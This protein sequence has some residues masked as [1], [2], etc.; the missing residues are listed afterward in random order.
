MILPQSTGLKYSLAFIASLLLFGFPLHAFADKVVTEEWQISADKITRYDNPQSIIAEGNIVL[1]KR[2]KLPPKPVK[3]DLNVTDWSVLLEEKPQVEQI[4]PKDLETK[5]KARYVTKVTIKADWMA[6]DVTLGTI[7]ARGHVD[8]LSGDERLFAEQGVVNLTRDTGTFTNA[9]IIRKKNELHLEGKTI[10]KTGVHTYRILDGWA[11]TCKVDKGE[12]SPWSFSSKDTKITQGGYAVMKNAK[13]NI[14]GVPVFY[15]PFMV[16]PIKNTRETGFLFPEISTSSNNGYGFNLPFFY[17]I[18]DSADMT[19]YSEYYSKRG[20]M[21]GAEF[22][23]VLEPDDKGTFA[24][25]YLKDQ[26]SDP[27]ETQYYRDTGF[28]HT[29]DQR[30][31]V[32]GKIDKTFGDGWITRVDLDIVSDRDYLTE[33]NSSNYTGFRQSNQQFLDAFGRGFQDKTADQRQ[34]AVSVLKS[35]KGMSLVTDLLAINDVRTNKTSPTPLWKLPEIDFTGATPINNSNF[36]FNWDANYVDYWRKDGVGANRID[37]SP[38][39]SSPIPLGPYLESRAEVGLRETVYQ[40]QAYGDGSWDQGNNPTRTLYN[41]HTE[42]GTTLAR[43]FDIGLDNFKGINH[44]V[45]PF[46][47]YDYIPD[48]NQNDLPSFDGIDRINPANTITYGVD[49]FFTL[50]KDAKNLD[51]DSTKD[52]SYLKIKQSY[53]LDDVRK[54]ISYDSN[55]NLLP[56]DETDKVLSPINMKFGWKPFENLDIIYKTDLDVYGHGFIRHSAEGAFQNSRGDIFDLDYQYSKLLNIEQINLHAKTWLWTSIRGEILLSQSLSES[57][58]NEQDISIAYQAPCW[59][60]EI[61]ST[62]TPTDSGVYLIFNLA[63][64]STPLGMSF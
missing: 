47:Q 6:Y 16:I 22:R 20:F 4:T 21:P 41:I 5:T 59:S 9:T 40:V 39:I 55:S 61:R 60:V 24:A 64:I 33:F 63:N 49:N 57:T 45:R 27:S 26:L 43:N 30:Y 36:T 29:N 19:F 32:R 51:A 17:N 35:W 44:K 18:S 10:E 2:E 50:F 25:S 54:K 52:Y 37:L 12:T 23:Y 14:K 56:S 7:K 46:V 34:N 31:W 11:I 13:F 1:V 58:T 53:Y 15:T 48:V 38:K 8:I 28:T 3:K 42:L 62:Y